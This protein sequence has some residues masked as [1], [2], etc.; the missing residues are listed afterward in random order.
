MDRSVVHDV[1]MMINLVHRMVYFVPEADAEYGRFGVDPAGGYFGSR[2]AP[3]GAVPD[4]VIISTFYNFSP[5]AVTLAMPGV[6]AAADP[7]EWQAAR[8]RVVQQSLSRVGVN[9]TQDEITEA[10]AIVDPVVAGLNLGGKPLAAANS[11]VALPDDPLSALWQQI[12]VIR[13]WRGDVHI[14]VLV[15]NEIGP[16][17]CLAMQVGA[18]KFPFRLARATRRWTDD[19][20]TA[21]QKRLAARGWANG[22]GTLTSDGF[23]AR[24]HVESETDRLCET[25]WRDVG[26]A[27]ATRLTELIAPINTAITEAGTYAALA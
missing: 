20:W 9:L 13:E 22:D 14:A 21:A 12:T 2:S 23:E 24:E 15:T 6:W 16:S 27:G 8:F 5:R 3:M 26:D 25:I 11:A 1:H 10:R 19:E 4:A 7:E 18:G 17:D